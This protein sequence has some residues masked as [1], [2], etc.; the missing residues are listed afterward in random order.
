MQRAI[1]AITAVAA[2]AAGIWMNSK[3][4]GAPE[5]TV[6]VASDNLLA[7][8]LDGTAIAIAANT[9]K[10]LLINF[11]A[12][13][14]KPCVE[15]LPLLAQF[16]EQ[17]S[18][19]LDVLAVAIDS[20]ANVDAF[21]AEHPSDLRFAIGSTQVSQ[22][23]SDWGNNISALPFSVLLDTSGAKIA[24]QLGPFDADTLANFVDKTHE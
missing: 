12:S 5:T 14:C 8:A 22:A 4:S 11:W 18:Q 2:L 6:S 23:M 1:V 19:T 16:A 7:T 17:R 10:P 3:T 13:W 9:E 20:A 15:E 24:S 21:L